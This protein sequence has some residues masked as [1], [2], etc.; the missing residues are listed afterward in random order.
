MPDKQA[1]WDWYKIAITFF[2]K[3]ETT[4]INSSLGDIF[5]QT[6]LYILA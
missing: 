1:P 3:A 5:C 4:K 2:K 6:P